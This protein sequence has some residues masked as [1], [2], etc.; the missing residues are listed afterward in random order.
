MGTRA[1]RSVADD[2]RSRSVEQLQM[3]LLNRP[4]VV[5]PLPADL[6]ELAT[7]VTNPTSVRMALDNLDS[8]QLALLHE[9]RTH[10]GVG[11]LTTLI[12]DREIEPDQL[13]ELWDRALLWGQPPSDP[14]AALFVAGPV[15]TI[16]DEAFGRG[17]A[18]GDE[19]DGEAVSHDQLQET[20]SEPEEIVTVAVTGFNESG[21]VDASQVAMHAVILVDDVA[22]WIRSARPSFRKGGGIG[23]RELTSLSNELELEANQAG[24]WL[25]L[26]A[27]AGFLGLAATDSWGSEFEVVLTE[28]FDAWSRL[29]FV[30]QWLELSRVWSTTDLAPQLINTENFEGE[31]INALSGK[32]KLPVS[33]SVRMAVLR[34]LSKVNA[35]HGLRESGIQQV[36]G[37]RYPRLD[38]SIRQEVVKQAVTE[39][40]WLGVVAHTRAT[41]EEDTLFLTELGRTWMESRV[42][43]DEVDRD[44]KAV[45]MQFPAEVDQVIT[46]AD[47]TFVVP[48]PPAPELRCLLG[49]IARR[50]STG[51]ATVY[52][53]TPETLRTS[54]AVGAD[55]REVLAELEGKS[56]TPIPQPMQYLVSD[57][58]KSASVAEDDSDADGNGEVGP[59]TTTP[60]RAQ[61]S[62]DGY[63]AAVGNSK[64]GFGVPLSPDRAQEL[65]A[66]LWQAQ[67]DKTANR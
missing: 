54:V 67:Q 30:E 31:R 20:A 16:L 15:R 25:E 1:P 5:T 18:A 22:H 44:H 60:N 29:S 59:G 4:D 61:R 10:S 14:G 48:G 34:A 55:P 33:L 58:I 50:E 39:G 3:L 38:P 8:R 26:S 7:R 12:Q 9:L 6:T 42:L 23:V 41:G 66:T 19:E 62:L 11:S 17:A 35:G 52:R 2:I 27:Q 57:A 24:F 21:Q 65:A 45:A 13:Q 43:G 56:L 51:G 64:A 49:L 53:L 46:Q 28:S 47:M 63:L 36:A 32:A 40:Q 37:Q